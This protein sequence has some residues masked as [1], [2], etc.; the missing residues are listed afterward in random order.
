M[1]TALIFGLYASYRS[2]AALSSSSADTFFVRTNLACSVAG[3]NRV[4]RAS[5]D[6]GTVH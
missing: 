6:N 3:M 5:G 4:S 1:F 2:I